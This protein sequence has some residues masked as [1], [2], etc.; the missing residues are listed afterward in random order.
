MH[1]YFFID[2]KSTLS[3]RQIPISRDVLGHLLFNT[4]AGEYNLNIASAMVAEG[5]LSIWQER[6]ESI[7]LRLKHNIERITSI[8]QLHT[9]YFAISET[10][11]RKRKA[12]ESDIDTEFDIAMKPDKKK[13]P[14]ASIDERT[15]TISSG[16]RTSEKFYLI[17]SNDHKRWRH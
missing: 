8:K 7:E 1:F 2:P 10:K 14:E 4:I 13:K 9:K 3:K 17:V 16:E 6:R 12:F 5:I 15:S 11:N